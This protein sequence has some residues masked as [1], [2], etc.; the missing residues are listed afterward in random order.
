MF[1]PPKANPV[2]YRCMNY[3]VLDLET[4]IRNRGD[5]AIGKMQASPFHPDNKI[6]MYGHTRPASMTGIFDLETRAGQRITNLYQGDFLE[7]LDVSDIIVG[8]NL[9]FDMLYLLMHHKCR[10][11]RFLRN[12]GVIWDTMQAEYLLT[13]HQDQF[14]PLGNKYKKHVEPK[15]LIKQ[16]MAEKYGGFDKD[17]RIA[18]YWNEGIDTPDIPQEELRD[19][20]DGDLSNTLI[21]FQHQYRDTLD[22]GPDFTALVQTQMQAIVAT[23]MCEYN[24]MHFDI[25]AASKEL[26]VLA[27]EHDNRETIMQNW[28]ADEI[29][30]HA[31]VGT[32]VVEAADCNPGSPQ[33]LSTVLMGGVFKHTKRLPMEDDEGKPLFIKTGPNKGQPKMKNFVC[34]VTIEEKNS[35]LGAHVDTSVLTKNTLGYVLDNDVIPKLIDEVGKT[36]AAGVFLKNVL[37][38]RELSKDINTYY[39]GLLNLTWPTDSCIH[40]TMNHCATG[41]GRLSSSAP[42]MQNVSG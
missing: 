40:G 28:M 6:H 11:M 9:K 8:Q 32:P 42:N 23:T 33:Q 24:G 2:D 12:G 14:A 29:N 34:H 13:N 19:Y 36:T 5:D 35:A 20:L 31:E 3:M 16:G 10:F 7:T 4:T 21:V 26:V 17:D 37:K 18:E 41:T 27:K 38:Y 30:V 1:D 39:I 15:V 22:N 25:D